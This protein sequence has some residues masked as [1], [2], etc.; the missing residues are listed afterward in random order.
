MLIIKDSKPKGYTWLLSIGVSWLQ[1]I[2]TGRNNLLI[3]GI[4]VI[5][6]YLLAWFIQYFL[7][8]RRQ[9]KAMTKKIDELEANKSGLMG[10]IT[11]Y[12]SER[13]DALMQNNNFKT[14]LT[15]LSMT[16]PDVQDKIK[17]YQSV[18]GFINDSEKLAHSKD[19]Q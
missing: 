17:S 14:I 16:I 10:M 1:N 3:S 13:D 15:I 8:L 7:W 12:K 2:V 19:N 6:V 9:N 4:V 18:E 11:Q 5:G